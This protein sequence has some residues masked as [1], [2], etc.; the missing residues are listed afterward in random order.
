MGNIDFQYPAWYLVFC[1]LAGLVYALVLYYKDRSFKEHSSFLTIG[2]G[3]LRFLTV[4]GISALL[5]SPLVKSITTETQNPIVVIAQDV[6]E[7]VKASMDSLAL[8][9]YQNNLETL[10]NN[11]AENYDVKTY[12]FGENTTPGF[13]T[14]YDNKKTNISGVFQELYNLYSN[15]NLGAI[16][17]ATDGIYNAG[18]NPLYTSA[19][20]PVA[21]YSVA[22]GDTTPVKDIAL[23]RVF[24]NKIAYLGDRFSIQADITA[25]NLAGN[26]SKLSIYKVENGKNT[27]LQEQNIV[28]SDNNFFTTSEVILDADKAGVQHYRLSVSPINGENTT[29]NNTRDIF[30]DVL[31]AR[32]KILILAHSPHPDLAALRQSITTNKNY[33]VDVVF[34]GEKRITLKEYDMLILHQIPSRKQSVGMLFKAIQ[35]EKIPTLYIAGLQTNY[36][37]LNRIQSLMTTNVSGSSTN[38]VQGKWASDFSLF[39]LSEELKSQLPQYPPLIAPFGEAE[40]QANASTL[41]YQRIGKVDTKYPLWVLGEQNNIRTGIILGEGLWKWRLFDY[42]QHNNHDLFNELIGK[43]VQYLSLKEDKRRFRVL[44]GKNIFDENE[45]I[46]F[47]AELYDS[48]YELTNTPDVDVVITN[49]E[50]RNYTFVFD[51]TTQGYNLNAGVLP[52]GNYTYLAKTSFNGEQMTFSGR[53]GVQPLQ[54]ELFENQADHAMLYALSGDSGGEVVYPQDITSISG[55]I[56][57][58][59][60]IK[61]VIYQNDKV[62]PLINSKWLFFLL[63]LLLTIEWFGRRYFG[64]Y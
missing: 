24:H 58:A 4:T 32:Q 34:V 12:S 45:A 17:L 21:V 59:T 43:T 16:V 1:V 63:L 44:A 28:V 18:S 62:S 11:L 60:Q 38:E 25:R 26:N 46:V 55:K 39:K 22:L 50:G 19:K 48:N 52:V 27:K 36:K 37:E 6:S 61:P 13:S 64:A 23:K 47:D 51:K 56:A 3:V 57:N 31:D 35:E 49:E 9:A 54:L 33:E 29:Q 2:L 41:L 42:L 20:L 40:T 5:L 53:F 14:E 30:V 10:K 15:Q 8:K 7:S